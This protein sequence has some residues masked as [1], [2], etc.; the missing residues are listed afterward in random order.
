VVEVVARKSVVNV[1]P[2]ST[3]RSSVNLLVA[4]LAGSPRIRGHLN[5]VCHGLFCFS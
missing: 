4:S 2:N 3:G 5:N 1:A